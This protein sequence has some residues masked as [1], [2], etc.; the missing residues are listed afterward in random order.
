MKS[1]TSRSVLPSLSSSRMRLFRSTA[2]AAC[3]SARVW[4]WHTRQ[5]SSSAS[6]MT[7]FSRIG[8]SCEKPGAEMNRAMKKKTLCTLQLL[9][10]RQDAIAHDLGRESADAL[11][12]DHALLVD[13][14]RFRHAV[15][16]VIHAEPAVAVVK[17]HGEGVAEA[18]QPGEGLAALVLVVEAHHRRG[19]A[20]REG[21]ERRMLLAA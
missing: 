12:A 21:S 3:E 15:D 4:F 18:R 16:A 8:L 17:R 9:H 5:R 13:D 14:E 1:S 19:A 10:E 20:A 2:S 11:V 7:R 6:A